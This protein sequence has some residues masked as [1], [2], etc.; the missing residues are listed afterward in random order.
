[1]KVIFADKS[2]IWW[3]HLIKLRRWKYFSKL[4]NVLQATISAYQFLPKR[5]YHSFTLKTK[6][7]SH[8]YIFLSFSPKSVTWSRFPR[9][10]Y[11]DWNNF[12]TRFI[13]KVVSD[14]MPLVDIICKHVF[15]HAYQSWRASNESWEGC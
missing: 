12:W 14:T 5:R 4:R 6:M 1:M 2:V 8:D 3:A 13:L 15:Q 11:V 10:L 7:K 9:K